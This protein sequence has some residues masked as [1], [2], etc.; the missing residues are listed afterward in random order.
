MT[1]DWRSV[2]EQPAV[3]VDVSDVMIPLA[4]LRYADPRPAERKRFVLL[5]WADVI[6]RFSPSD[7]L[8][9]LDQELPEGPEAPAVPHLSEAAVRAA[10]LLELN[11]HDDAQGLLPR[12]ATSAGA[13]ALLEGRCAMAKGAFSDARAHYEVA[14]AV[15]R[16]GPGPL[17]VE[18]EV[19]AM[20]HLA[21]LGLVEALAENPWFDRLDARCA[22][23]GAGF[24][25]ST[26]R[27][28][29][30]HDG[31]TANALRADRTWVAVRSFMER[32]YATP[33]E[34]DRP[35]L[36]PVPLHVH[37]IAKVHHLEP[38]AYVRSI[39]TLAG[40]MWRDGDR[41]RAYEVAWYGR[42][43]G[44]RLFGETIE[45]ALSEFLDQLLA[46]LPAERR[47]AFDLRLRLNARRAP[48]PNPAA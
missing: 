14:V 10:T 41:Q 20:G 16:Q 46:P 15:A 39:A 12:V 28:L 37:G 42:A 43:V 11:R 18:V 21:R 22:E 24:T 33:F 17:A 2:T 6:R 8:D 25:R 48:K 32:R 29:R 45:A 36:G 34:A 27:W 1:D 47:D 19:E 38:Q 3:L 40:L 31:P 7:A 13:R 4:R 26:F 44:R 9:V 35:K 30:A 23:I 5:R